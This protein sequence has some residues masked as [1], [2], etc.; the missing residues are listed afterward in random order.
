MALDGKRIAAQPSAFCM[1]EE[2]SR[3]DERTPTLTH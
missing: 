1:S 3:T 2:G